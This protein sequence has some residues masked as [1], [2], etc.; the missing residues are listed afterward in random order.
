MRETE[1]TEVV[2]RILAG[3]LVSLLSLLAIGV[4]IA[5]IVRNLGGKST[6]A[7]IAGL[8]FVA[9]LAKEFSDYVGMNDPQLLGQAVMSAGFAIFTADYRR[10]VNLALAAVLMVVAGFIKHNIFAMPLAATA[11][12]A[13]HDRPALLR[14]LACCLVP[15]AIGFA[16]CFA[17][18][19]WIFFEQLT[20]PRPY[21][22]I[23]DLT[24]LGR[25]QAFIIP[26][27]LWVGAVRD[28]RPDPNI[29]LVTFLIIA[30]ALAYAFT[31]V[32]DDVAGNAMFDWIIAANVALGVG[33]S[34]IGEMRFAKRLGAG[35]A[36]GIVVIALSLRLILP[37][38]AILS[39][40]GA[41]LD[42]LRSQADMT[43]QDV[44][45]LR[46]HAGPSLCEELAACY[47][48]GHDSIFDPSNGPPAMDLG[49]RNVAVLKARIATGDLR[50]LQLNRDS[51]FLSATELLGGYRRYETPG[52]IFFYR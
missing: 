30:G 8:V 29:R 17:V 38:P 48:A 32:G 47:W 2:E 3:R 49:L 27:I 31:Q 21:H 19:G 1:V 14:W 44:A 35:R 40:P 37:V 15:L 26:L 46:N 41:L 4:N 36:E 23:R 9:T 43:S 22:L 51:A 25:I 11:W 52:S 12:L 5:R 39:Y 20:E 50:L 33:I 24:K 34:R 28:L 42:R 7:I 10:W 18:Y 16:A 45:F 13:Y 6:P